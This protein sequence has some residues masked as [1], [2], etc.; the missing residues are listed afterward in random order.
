MCLSVGGSCT[1]P[2]VVIIME[3]GG[4]T[5]RLISEYL[6]DEPNPVPIILM[7]GTGR[8]TDFLAW[9][10]RTFQYPGELQLS[11]DSVVERIGKIFNL[12]RQ[13]AFEVFQEC[14]QIFQ[15]RSLVRIL[16][17]HSSE[18]LIAISRSFYSTS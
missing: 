14:E 17:V 6:Y 10:L 18:N 8:I 7:A 9:M 1:I 4:H 16:V 2:L 11:M 15:K 3:G 5:L 12:H 13:A